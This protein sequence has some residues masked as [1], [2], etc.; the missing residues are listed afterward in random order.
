MHA[1]PFAKSGVP[2]FAFLAICTALQATEPPRPGELDRY[3]KDG[4]YAERK[5]FVERTGNHKVRP[6]VAARTL[7]RLRPPPTGNQAALSLLPNW[8]GMPT[9]GTNKVL[10]FLI[11]FPDYP[12]T[13]S[14]A[15]IESKLFANGDAG[16]YPLESL[17]NYYLRSSYSN[18]TIT[19]STLGWYRMQHAR[20]W[21]TNTYGSGNSANRAVIAEVVANFEGSHDYAQYDN[22][23]DGK[24][25]Y[26]AVI[27]AGPDNGWGNFWWGYQWE[28]TS[29]ITA[30]GVQ[31]S[32][33][34][35]QWEAR[36]VGTAF[37]ASTIIHETG[38]ALGLPDYYDYSPGVGPEGGL[39]GL[40]MM[41]AAVG[42]HNCFSKFMLEWINPTV[43]SAGTTT[44]V[45]RASAQWP[46]AAAI[47]PGYTGSTPFSEYFMV[48]NR[49]RILND[50][51]L[52]TASDG[53]LV[54]HIDATPNAGGNDFRYNNSDTSHKL[55]RLMEADGLEQIEGGGDANAGDYYNAGETFGPFATPSSQSYSGS[56][57][58]VTVD[59][60]SSNNT[61]MTARLSAEIPAGIAV[62][63]R[64]PIALS[65][66]ASHGVNATSQTFQ[67]QISG[68]HANYTIS[69]S[70]AWLSASP[71]FG[72][73]SN[74]TVTHTLNYN[75][76]ALPIGSYTNTL[77]ILSTNAANSNLT[78]SVA[79]SIF[80]TN[81]AAA[82]DTTNLTWT[83]GGNAPWIEQTAVSKD[84]IDAT[85]SG[86]IGDNSSTWVQT[87][88][89]GPATLTYWWRVSSEAGYD[90]LTCSVNGVNQPGAISGL[91]E[92]QQITLPL[93]SGTHTCRWTYAKDD[94]V[95]GG[96][97]AA[98]LD[99]VSLST[100]NVASL[101]G[102]ALDAPE[103]PWTTGG[104][105]LWTA[106]SSTTHD[107]VDAAQ[108]GA[109][110]SNATTWVQTTVT[111]P[112][113]VKFWGKVSSELDYDYLNVAIDGTNQNLSLS[114]EL[115]WREYLIRIPTGTHTVTWAYTK[116]LSNS[117]GTDAAW[118]DSVSFSN[119][120]P[121]APETLLQ[122]D[123]TGGLPAGWS[124][125]DLAGYGATWSLSNP[126]GRPN[127]TGGSGAF[128]IADSDWA[129][130]AD[131]DTRLITPAL[132]FRYHTNIVLQFATDYYPYTKND[133]PYSYEVGA[134]E[135]STN[136]TDWIYLWDHARSA[137]IGPATVNLNS[138]S[139]RNNV[140]IAFHYYNA[141]YDNWWQVDNVRIEASRRPLPTTH[142]ALGTATGTNN[143]AFSWSASEGYCT[144]LYS[145]NLTTGIWRLAPGWISNTPANGTMIYTNRFT[146]PFTAYRLLWEP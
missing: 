51:G 91:T 29:P 9:T 73:G 8:Q 72:S 58:W 37:K 55:L 87:V 33:F 117:N 137:I 42:D 130:Y 68:S 80:G 64:A 20:S 127:Y 54:W 139:G 26:F 14:A 61:S 77:S 146:G 10:V 41:D 140:R 60:F 66:T 89:Q 31:F 62:L 22:N 52:F 132:D 36:P 38:H 1:L 3:Q 17:R 126:G 27:W 6:D 101:L 120:L 18:L 133:S 128:A 13:N 83:T 135:Y 141:N 123:F 45:L 65:Q 15:L 24:I 88:V 134:V 49:H 5:A 4:S 85:Q 35:W 7:A 43:V 121:N 104:N 143:V 94:T 105:G 74:V 142:I 144:V 114:G 107:G 34:S 116:D 70:A 136:G 75:T 93:P 19:G 119:E 69:N 100:G 53:A 40:D 125:N 145:T 112:L 98:W 103:K 47:M 32:S 108:S 48:Q 76:A 131:M 92:W 111:G 79:L 57:T 82:V 81:I 44:V 118:L 25:D 110:D 102:E 90:F 11:D 46:S 56:N 95:L 59:A 50:T 122:T 21:Y 96:M 113:L 124:A 16:E 67:V 129:G 138:L 63:S 39:G 115:D 99:C 28:L 2:L 71:A 30:D 23:G 97:D 84:D 109:I 86:A 78:L 106:I 12:H